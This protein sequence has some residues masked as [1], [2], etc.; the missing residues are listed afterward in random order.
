MGSV[1]KDVARLLL[2][3]G[4]E[5][6]GRHWIFEPGQIFIELPA[7]QLDAGARS[8]N[9]RVGSSTVLTI[10]PE[11]LVVDRLAAWQFWNSP[12]D[13][14]NAFLVARASELDDARLARLAKEE[15]VNGS[16]RSL[17]TF[18]RKHRKTVPAPEALAAWANETN[19]VVKP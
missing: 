17:K 10:A 19:Q 14:V 13:A 16:L 7:R 11:E 2:E 5:R 12:Q 15:E 6:A 8:V 1:P 3:Q 4:F 18:L 9:L